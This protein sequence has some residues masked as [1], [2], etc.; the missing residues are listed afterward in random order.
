MRAGMW[1]SGSPT[2][3]DNKHIRVNGGAIMQQFDSFKRE[4]L[5]TVIPL[6]LDLLDHDVCFPTCTCATQNIMDHVKLQYYLKSARSQ[7]VSQSKPQHNSQ[8]SSWRAGS[9]TALVQKVVC[10]PLALCECPMSH[11]PSNPASS[12]PV[13]TFIHIIVNYAAIYPRARFAKDA[14]LLTIWPKDTH[15]QGLGVD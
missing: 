13:Y 8:T 14:S 1:H 15:I 3:G 7:R 11:V 2:P 10:K 12:M 9:D 6:Y 5:K 4:I